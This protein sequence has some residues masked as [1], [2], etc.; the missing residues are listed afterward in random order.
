MIERDSGEMG[1]RANELLLKVD[2]PVYLQLRDMGLGKNLSYAWANGICSPSSKA[3]RAMALAGY[4]VMY[5]LT[6]KRS[7]EADDYGV[8]KEQR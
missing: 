5:I 8:R 3:L 1:L 2:K 4:D 6:G 7:K